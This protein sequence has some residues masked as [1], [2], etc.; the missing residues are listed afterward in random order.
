M[1]GHHGPGGMNSYEHAYPFEIAPFT[2][3][4][5]AN[6]AEKEKEVWFG[7]AHLHLPG[8]EKNTNDYQM[9][10]QF[11]D[12]YAK[13]YGETELKKIA[14]QIFLSSGDNMGLKKLLL[15]VGAD[16]NTVDSNGENALFH[17]KGM[18]HSYALEVGVFLISNGLDLYHK[19]NQ[20]QTVIDILEKK[21]DD[22]DVK[23]IIEIL[24]CA[25][26][27][28]D[29]VIGNWWRG[30]SCLEACPLNSFRYR[31]DQCVSCDAMDAIE[32]Q[33]EECDKCGDKRFMEGKRCVLSDCGEG[34]FRDESGN[35]VSC[36]SENRISSTAEECA[37]CVDKNGNPI[38]EMYGKRCGLIKC[39][40]GEFED[41]FGNCV[42]CSSENGI[43]ASDEDCTKCVDENG[44]PMREMFWGRCKIKC[45]KGEFRDK[46]GNCVSCSSI[47]SIRSFGEECAKC[48]DEDGNPMREMHWDSCRLMEFPKGTF[49]DNKGECKPCNTTRFISTSPEECAKCVDEDGNPMREMY[50]E[51]CGLK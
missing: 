23:H 16:V 12:H 32:T 34:K 41:R 42:P 7:I 4:D 47:D 31:D 19:N 21:K 44:N 38:R 39:S 24:K 3:V 20:G 9:I 6:T 1:Q 43:D 15:D 51:R 36:S 13:S 11:I 45:P 5:Y 2:L 25:A 28:D 18:L 40:D 48:V 37:K 49:K 10:R 17:I 35:C 26:N 27:P 30:F 50:G 22:K 14:N 29:K 8:Y 46:T 33:E